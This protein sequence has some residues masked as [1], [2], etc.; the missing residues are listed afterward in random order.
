MVCERPPRSLRSRLPL[1]RGRIKLSRCRRKSPP[2]E[3]ETRAKRAR[4]ALTRHLDFL[5]SNTAFRPWLGSFAAP[6]LQSDARAR[7]IIFPECPA[8]RKAVWSNESRRYL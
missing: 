4:G 6:R 7:E 3:G 2:R 1:T 5:L 8:T